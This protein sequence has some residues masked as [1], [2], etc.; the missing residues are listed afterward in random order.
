MIKA[1]SLILMTAIAG[2]AYYYFVV[3]K[4]SNT[5]NTPN[6]PQVNALM[7]TPPS[8]AGSLLFGAV[9]QQLGRA[10]GVGWGVSPQTVQTID[11]RDGAIGNYTGYSQAD[12]NQKATDDFNNQF[13][14]PFGVSAFQ[15]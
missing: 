11:W 12:A 7:G 2:G 15:F 13:I 6:K 4:K 5:N 1:S 8:T 3:S 9:S 10:L 14:S